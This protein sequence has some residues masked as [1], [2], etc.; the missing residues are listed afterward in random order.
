MKALLANVSLRWAALWLTAGMFSSTANAKPGDLDTAYGGDGIATTTLR[1]PRLPDIEAVIAGENTRFFLPCRLA[2]SMVTYDNVCDLLLSNTAIVLSTTG[3]P[4]I[5]TNLGVSGVFSH[6]V[7]PRN[8]DVVIATRCAPSSLSTDGYCIMR[9][10][11]EGE[12]DNSFNNDTRYFFFRDGAPS[13]PIGNPGQVHIAHDGRIRI[14]GSCPVASSESGD[15]RACV[16]GLT[17]TGSPDAA[18]KNGAADGL[19]TLPPISA[20]PQE[21]AKDLFI[22]PDGS[23]VV[24]GACKVGSSNFGCIGTLTANGTVSHWA[25]FN[26]SGVD[27]DTPERLFPIAPNQFVVAGSAFPTLSA[28]YPD[29]FY[30]GITYNGGSVGS[31]PGWGDTS[32]SRFKGA[33]FR[34]GVKFLFGHDRNIYEVSWNGGDPTTTFAQLRRVN[35]DGSGYDLGFG[36]DVTGV[37]QISNQQTRPGAGFAMRA[38]A[39]LVIGGANYPIASQFISARFKNGITNQNVACSLDIDGDGRFLATTDGLLAARIAN[40]NRGTA[41][42]QN[43]IGAGAAR[44]NWAA[45]RDHL[46]YRCRLRLA[47]SAVVDQLADAA[48]SL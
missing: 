28:I 16:I 47:S 39:R 5:L 23:I 8:G 19:V 21:L 34:Y 37:A 33:Q 24:L 46:F 36:N 48:V 20:T 4:P 44:S 17:E 25:A 9:Y 18:F 35:G 12:L 15:R 32:A 45:I 14:A 29:G 42:T 43:A 10:R 27:R 30:Q 13:N 3:I 26:F 22:R 7:D 31:L 1:V 38:D 2:R 11:A 6:A 40:G 41:T